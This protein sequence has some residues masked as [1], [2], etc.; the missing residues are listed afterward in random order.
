M[1]TSVEKQK[2]LLSYLVSSQDLFIKTS[3]ILK[4]GYFDPSL[5]KAVQFVLGYFNEYKAPPSLEQIKAETGLTLS[6][7]ELSKAEIS[8]AENQ[9]ETFCRN[10]ACKEAAFM[11][12]S[13]LKE[14][15]Y[16]DMLKVMQEA[17]QISL[18][19]DIGI[20]Y[21]D[22]PEARLKI[23]TLNNNTIPTLIHKLDENLGGGI[24]RKEMIIFAAPSGVGKSITMSNVAKNLAKQG[25][26][27]VYFTLEL[28]EEI[29][30][31]RFDSMFSGIAQHAI[32]YNITQTAIEVRKQS[33]SSGRLFIK[34]MPES[35]TN[36]NHLRAYLK[37]FEI[38]NGFVPDFIVVDYLDLMASVQSVSVENQFVKDKYVSEELRAIANDYNAFMIT[39]SQLNRGAQQLESLDDL[40]Q[41]HIAGG[42]SKVNTTDVLCAIIQ[43]A[44]M[45]AR[46]EMMFKLLKTR[47][48]SGVGNYFMVKFNPASLLLENLEEGETRPDRTLSSVL[49]GKLARDRKPDDPAAPTVVEPNKPRPTGP[50]GMGINNIPFQV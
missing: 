29:V 19:R 48:S 17:I 47:N 34:R 16:G 44:Q 31:K 36:A 13:L 14:A 3:P 30:A 15:K 10:S 43:T 41:A 24:T 49:R 37:E 8:Y 32:L 38:V 4:A 5:K 45:K 28:S 1:E 25:L 46:Q 50:G 35:S 22:D 21:F 11:L 9:F 2:L 27:G 23:L 42:I 39:A 26:H 12:P 20:N 7:K 40:S 33:E 18:S 6:G